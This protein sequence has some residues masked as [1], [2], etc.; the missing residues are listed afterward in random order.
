MMIRIISLFFLTIVLTACDKKMTYS[1]LMTHPQVL[2]TAVEK[3][4][5]DNSDEE[6]CRVVSYAAN[7]MITIINEQQKDP[8]KF[9]EK[10]MQSQ[11][12]LS[13]LEQKMQMAKA[14]LNTL[15]TSSSNLK[16]AQKDFAEAQ[17]AYQD[18]KAEVQVMLAVL[19]LGSPEP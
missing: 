6:T 12:Q 4:Q 18:K 11:W 1:Y 8:E 5:E 13:D 17:K 3:C 9:G 10:L 16:T 7:N 14:K 19:G 15:K 2:Q